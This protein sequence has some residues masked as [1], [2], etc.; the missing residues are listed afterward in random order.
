MDTETY[1]STISLPNEMW[2]PIPEFETLYYISSYGRILRLPCTRIF[3]RYGK[4]I[5]TDVDYK[6]LKPQ[7]S[8]QN[9]RYLVI[10]L[11]KDKRRYAKSVHRLVA[12]S[13]IPNPN[14]YPI[15]N[16]KDCN[17]H[18]NNIENLEWCTQYFNA[19]YEPTKANMRSSAAK[20]RGIH[21]IKRDINGNIICE[22]ESIREASRALHICR[23][24][25]NAILNNKTTINYGYKLT[26]S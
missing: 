9:N 13:F 21:I 8:G 12:E 22:Y 24:T 16:H 20:D 2:K 17:G 11:F 3:H 19:N 14:K 5:K 23:Q 4:L 1:I 10:G 26:K 7:N 15:I 6:I 18:N 25:V